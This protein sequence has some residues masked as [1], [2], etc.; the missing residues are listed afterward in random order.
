MSELQ[1]Q[2][3]DFHLATASDDAD[4]LLELGCGFVLFEGFLALPRL[5][6]HE[7]VLTC[8]TFKDIIGNHAFVLLRLGSKQDGCF[9]GLIVLALL[10]LEKTIQS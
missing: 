6:E 1:L 8:G 4:A 3:L 5:A 9:K 10:G 2:L 7:Y